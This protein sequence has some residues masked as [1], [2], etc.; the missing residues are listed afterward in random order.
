M[1]LTHVAFC[2]LVLSSGS[3][4]AG[5]LSAAFF[6]QNVI[7]QIMAMVVSSALN[8]NHQ[9][10]VTRS[11]VSANHWLSSIKINRLPWYLTLVSANHPS[12]NSAQ[13]AN[14]FRTED[15]ILTTILYR[16]CDACLSNSTVACE[17]RCPA[18]PRTQ[19]LLLFLAS[20]GG[21]RRRPWVRGCVQLRR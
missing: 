20:Y 10:P 2:F 9:G 11:M 15:E 21:K 4:Q 6:K 1:C 16:R 7:P 5:L 13:N 12:N 18:Q 17:V 3:L 14:A 8:G 19:G